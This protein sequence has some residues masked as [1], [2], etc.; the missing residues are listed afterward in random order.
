MLMD[1]IVDFDTEIFDIHH[2]LLENSK[3]H[4]TKHSIKKFSAFYLINCTFKVAKLNITKQY[5]R[6]KQRTQI[7]PHLSIDCV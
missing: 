2:L 1:N 3:F 5:L 7:N 4:D 6:P